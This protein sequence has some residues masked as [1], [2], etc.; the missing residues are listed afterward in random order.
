VA[1][2]RS[3]QIIDLLHR[4]PELAEEAPFSMLRVA[5]LG[6]EA[7][8]PDGVLNVLNGPARSR[9]ARSPPLRAPMS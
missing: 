8:I 2:D 5:E 6:A 7:G 9:V 4:E 1:P 3:V